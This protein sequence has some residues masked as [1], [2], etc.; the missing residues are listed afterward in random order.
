MTGIACILRYVLPQLDDMVEE[1]EGDIH[2]DEDEHEITSEVN[3]KSQMSQEESKSNK[4][5]TKSNFESN[6][7]DLFGEM[8]EFDYGSELGEDIMD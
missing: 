6:L 5:E 2:S 8:G 7:D 4:S 3:D 1:D